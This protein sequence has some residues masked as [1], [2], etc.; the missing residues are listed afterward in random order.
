MTRKEVVYT[1][2][3]GVDL[4]PVPDCKLPFAE[5]TMRLEVPIKPADRSSPTPCPGGETSAATRE[6]TSRAQTR[7][8]P[9]STS[10]SPRTAMLRS[11]KKKQDNRFA[12]AVGNR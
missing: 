7:P 3:V 8:S 11:K 12:P 4:S 5:E 2:Y 9:M 10:P 1:L 6:L